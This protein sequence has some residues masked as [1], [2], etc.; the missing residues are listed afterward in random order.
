[1]H[2]PCFLI[3]LKELFI[4]ELTNLDVVSTL[5]WWEPFLHILSPDVSLLD[6]IH[7]VIIARL[8]IGYSIIHLQLLRF[9]RQLVLE[10]DR[11]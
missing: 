5:L 11:N 4:P 8:L 10:H 2:L 3:L 9:W 7:I 1:M 6:V